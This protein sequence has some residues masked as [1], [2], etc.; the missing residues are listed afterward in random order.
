MRNNIR[1]LISPVNRRL[2]RLCDEEREKIDRT[3]KESLLHLGAPKRAEHFN[4][5]N[6]NK[7]IMPANE[8]LPAPNGAPTNSFTV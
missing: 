1:Q 6:P 3:K 8:K 5:E 7:R 2:L 4:G